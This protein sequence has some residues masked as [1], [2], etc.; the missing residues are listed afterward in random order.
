M[1]PKRLTHPTRFIMPGTN[2]RSLG[3][4]IKIVLK[5]HGLEDKLTE[6]KIFSLW[7][8]IMGA[9]IA[10]YTSRLS[11]KHGNLIV[12]LSSS[13]LRNE[14]TYAKTKIIRMINDELGKPVVQ[15]IVFR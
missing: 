7:E 6:A 3:D 14:L 8:K 15:D 10:K 1:K 13:V 2:E 12:Y 11:L 4:I 9:P 5:R